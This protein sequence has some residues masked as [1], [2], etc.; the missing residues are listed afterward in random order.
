MDAQRPATQGVTRRSSKGQGPIASGRPA[1]QGLKSSQFTPAERFPKGQPAGRDEHGTQTMGLNVAAHTLK[2]N[3]D[4]ARSQEDERIVVS[5]KREVLPRSARGGDKAG[6]SSG[7]R[8]R[9][10]KTLIKLPSIGAAHAEAVDDVRR[11]PAIHSAT[12]CDEASKHLV[13]LRR[14]A[15]TKQLKVR[16]DQA[17]AAFETT[18]RSAHAECEV[19]SREDLKRLRNDLAMGDDAVEETFASVVRLGDGIRNY[20]RGDVDAIL[21]KVVGLCQEQQ[22]RID[23]FTDMGHSLEE[24]RRAAVE[25]ALRGFV[26]ETRDIIPI[27]GEVQRAVDK[28]G[29]DLNELTQLNRKAVSDITCRLQSAG[30]EKQK[31]LQEKVAQ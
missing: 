28:R 17:F 2:K 1:S 30:L 9:H 18:S 31:N 20:K 12:K 15:L 21:H 3:L 8:K 27:R 10:S 7:S 5:G 16:R 22:L 25:G 6:G 19:R 24:Q 14:E 4:S 29:H 23:E 26:D 13:D 11:T